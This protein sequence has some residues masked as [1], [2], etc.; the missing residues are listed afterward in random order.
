MVTFEY[1][2]ALTYKVNEHDQKQDKMKK[3]E[4]SG[5]NHISKPFSSTT[6]ISFMFALPAAR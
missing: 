2:I 4:W 1:G 3:D 5:K 6:H